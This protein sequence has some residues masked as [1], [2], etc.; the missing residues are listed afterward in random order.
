MKAAD[1]G[2]LVVAVALLMKT[3]FFQDIVQP[4][5]AR[6][7]NLLSFAAWEEQNPGGSHLEYSDYLL[8]V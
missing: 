8:G 3:G 7:D 5:G 1:L 4:P 2:G 6:P